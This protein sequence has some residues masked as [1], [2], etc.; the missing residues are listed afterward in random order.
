MANG[1]RNAVG[2][3]GG[4]TQGLFRGVTTG[5][6]LQQRQQALDRE[7]LESELGLFNVIA[8]LP[9]GPFKKASMGRFLPRIGFSQESTDLLL[10]ANEE[11][12][13][14]LNKALQNIMEQ[15]P[16][17]ISPSALNDLS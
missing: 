7:K 4:L 14:Y 17:A 2:A 10:K 8:K 9:D 12:Q 16:D 15:L 6:G 5:I 1:N 3:I 13:G 11:E